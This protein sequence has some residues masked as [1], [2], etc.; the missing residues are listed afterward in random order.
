MLL[1]GK[2]ALVT[3]GGRGLGWGIV[4]ALGD[5][6]A[7]V[8]LTDVDQHNLSKCQEFLGHDSGNRFIRYLD[9]SDLNQFVEVVD[10]VVNEWNRLDVLIH[11]AAI[12]PLVKY[13]DSSADSWWREI[14]ISLGG[15]INGT[16]ATWE[17]MKSQGGGHVIG[18]SS[19]SSFRGYV[20][21]VI[22][23]AG[24]HAQEG[25]VKALAL[26]ASSY[27]IALNT[28]GPGKKLKPTGMTWQ[29]QE[30]VPEALKVEWADPAD[31]GRAFVWLASQP[32]QRFSGLNFDAGPIVDAITNEG[33]DFS[34]TP[35]KVTSY[36]HE[37]EE[38]LLWQ[39]NYG[40]G[41][42]Q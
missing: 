5:A 11:A 24:K 39:A 37:F 32:P 23:C 38:R 20:D 4:Q 22:Y 19:T 30:E 16:R 15:L 2:V 17:T 42:V 34:V 29:Q 1:D 9:V 21:E 7:K 13:E 35:D 31:L 33:W 18:V 41:V 14:H 12:M 3:G 36:V 8:C 40:K 6:G 26:E 25:F 28:V 27:N 10:E